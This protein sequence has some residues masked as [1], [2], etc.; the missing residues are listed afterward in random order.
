M[1]SSRRFLFL[2]ARFGEIAH[3]ETER[4]FF[5]RAGDADR[6]QKTFLAFG[7]LRRTG[8]L[9]QALDDGGGDL[10]R[11]LHLALGE[12]GMG[13][14]ALDRDGGA[15]GRERLVLDIPGGFAVDGVGEI[16][17]ELFQVGLVDAA[18]DLFIGREQDL[19][20]AVPDLRIADQE[21]RGIHDFGEAGLVIGARAAWCRLM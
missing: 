11:V 8:V 1:P 18:A 4:G 7:G 16:G 3:D 17:A 9:G 13:A 20:G 12:T 10:D 19:D 5:Q 2:Q 15:V 6:V 21:M 14:D